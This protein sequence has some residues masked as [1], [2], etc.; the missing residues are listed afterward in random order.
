MTHK[1]VRTLALLTLA[2]A[3]GL[4]GA[5]VAQGSAV[6]MRT[7]DANNYDPHKTPGRA[8][9]EI[10][11]MLSDSLVS[12]APDL[13]TLEPGVDE[14][15]SM[16]PDGLTYTF[17]L[18]RD[19]KFCD[20]RPMTADD[21]VYSMKRWVDPETRATQ[22][23]RAGAVE[24]VIAV[25]PHTVRYVLKRPYSELLYQLTLGTAAIVDRHTVERLGNDFGVTGFNGVGPFCWESWKV[26]DELVL[27]RNEHYRWGPPQY[28]NR[29]PAK[30]EK[31]VWRVVP[32]DNTRITA[33]QTGQGDISY[34]VPFWAIDQLRKAPRTARS[35]ERRVGKECR[36]LCRSRWSPYH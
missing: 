4:P 32:E 29:G 19:V 13:R 22:R 33:L 36:R 1:L 16:S 25:D 26:R 11:T 23:S 8:G 18:R 15:W 9:W 5:A 24:D 7:N 27:R 20:G 28:Q 12:L 3:S 10:V 34:V 31:I 21:V 35:E 17:N 14:S 2:A 6:V 30:L